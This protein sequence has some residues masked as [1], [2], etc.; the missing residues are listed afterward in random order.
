METPPPNN[1]DKIAAL[2]EK[3]KG[4][5]PQKDKGNLNEGER[6]ILGIAA[7][8]GLEIVIALGVGLG[9]G[10]L[11]DKLFSTKPIFFLLFAL[12]G[13]AA[14]VLN[15]YRLVKGSEYR[16]GYKIDTQKDYKNKKEDRTE[17]L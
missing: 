15:V 6:Q 3:L 8:M 7:R 4:L 16:P 2:K 14:G 9:I 5:Q 1:N 17:D 10:Y 13:I 11:F 12:F